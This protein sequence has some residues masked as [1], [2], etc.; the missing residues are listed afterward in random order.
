MTVNIIMQAAFAGLPECNLNHGVGRNGSGKTAPG[1]ASF[2]V[3][4][5]CGQG[6][7]LLSLGPLTQVSDRGAEAKP[8]PL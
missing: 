2:S 5:A 6:D 1:K 7:D 3:Y 4:F 8:T